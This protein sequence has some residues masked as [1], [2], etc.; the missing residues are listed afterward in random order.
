ML[1]A[2]VIVILTTLLVW[3]WRGAVISE[4]RRQDLRLRYQAMQHEKKILFDFLHDLGEAFTEEIDRDQLLKIILQAARRVTEA[5]GAALYLWEG[6]KKKLQLQQVIGFF[7]PPQEVPEAL[8]QKIA[9]HPEVLEDFL[10]QELIPAE[11][12]TLLSQ[13]IRS[14]QP[15]W[16]QSVPPQ[17]PRFPRVHE[18]T[19]QVQTY[20]ALPLIYR[21][22]KMGVLALTNRE[23]PGG[24]TESDFEIVKSIADQAAFSLHSA[25]IYAQLAEKRKLDHDLEV[26]EEIQRILLPR[27]APELPEYQFAAVNIPAQRVSGDYY[28]FIQVDTYLWGLAIADVSG[29]GVPAS[30]IM[31]M[32]RSVLRSKA[33]GQASPAQVLREVNRQLFP[34]IREDMFITMIYAVLNTQTG[35]LRL[36]RAGHETPLLC[37]DQFA[38]VEPIAATGLALGIDPGDIF[39]QVVQDAIVPLGP[40]DTV[41]LYTDGVNEATDRAGREFGREKL[42]ATLKAAGPLGVDSLVKEVVEQVRRFSSGHAQNDDITIAVLQKKK[43]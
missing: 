11:S 41:V 35:E 37:R 33:P 16:L 2:L 14:G 10:K 19:L 13:V 39:D 28:D 18:P 5:K 43:L 3:K 26:A 23:G 15:V 8:A 22:E 36:A 12:N 1:S 38:T 25:H 7:P 6:G 32:C 40:L 20:L 42:I 29:K 9:T 24:F 27:Q 21:D 31:A 17:D 34:D 30:I 4:R